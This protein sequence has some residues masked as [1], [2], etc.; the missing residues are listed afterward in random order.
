MMCVFT[1]WLCARYVP[2]VG[3]SKRALDEYTSEIFMGGK[4][5]FCGVKFVCF[6]VCPS[7]PGQ[8]LSICCGIVLWVWG[9]KQNFCAKNFNLKFYFFSL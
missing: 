3:D 9:G 2:Y 4:V 8:Y 6:P 1:V 7:A 5:C